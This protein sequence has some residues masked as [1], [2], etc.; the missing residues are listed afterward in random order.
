M[1]VKILI[2]DPEDMQFY[3]ENGKTYTVSEVL[4]VDLV[5]RDIEA[6]P[7][8]FY[9]CQID[10]NEGIVVSASPANTR[11]LREYL[12]K[13]SNNIDH[14][15]KIYSLMFTGLDKVGL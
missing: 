3:D 7:S 5:Y 4:Q 10:P 1:Q 15:Q 9:L 8:G 14:L 2:I 13:L 12:V 6:N 11:D